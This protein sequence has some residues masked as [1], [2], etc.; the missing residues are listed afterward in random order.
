MVERNQGKPSFNSRQKMTNNN[1]DD[2]QNF[3]VK[4]NID[5]TVS[6]FI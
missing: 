5:D 1:D 2:N 3:I 4:N 6:K